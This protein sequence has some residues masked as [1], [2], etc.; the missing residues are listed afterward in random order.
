M[1]VVL[2]LLVVVLLVVVVVVGGG[3]GGGGGIGTVRV[4]ASVRGYACVL[5]ARLGVISLCLGSRVMR[6]LLSTPCGVLDD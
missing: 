6:R 5:C 2:L 1:V 4:C 3:G